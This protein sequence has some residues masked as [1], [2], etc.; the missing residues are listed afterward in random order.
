M[1]YI[2]IYMTFIFTCFWFPH[3]LTQNVPIN[4]VTYDPDSGFG[5][6][7]WPLNSD[8]PA[9]VLHRDPRL[10]SVIHL[11]IRWI[12]ASDAESLRHVTPGENKSRVIIRE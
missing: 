7:T 11:Q 3:V 8:P 9:G 4:A 5:H 6:V 10:A 12:R 2:D 1:L